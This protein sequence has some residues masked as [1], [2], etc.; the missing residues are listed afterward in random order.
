MAYPDHYRDPCDESSFVF[1]HNLL[2]TVPHSALAQPP[3][4][5]GGEAQTLYE[6]VNPCS[7]DIVA[8]SE[9][10]S[11][12]LL[13]NSHAAPKGDGSKQAHLPSGRVCAAGPWSLL[14][15]LGFIPCFHQGIVAP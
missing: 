7:D 2:S 12:W 5:R 9:C 8:P 4:I 6:N 1:Q 13:G 14:W 10:Y 3:G 15:V 11:N